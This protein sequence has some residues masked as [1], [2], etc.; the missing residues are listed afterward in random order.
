MAHSGKPLGLASGVRIAA[1]FRLLM[2]VR[3]LIAAVTVLLVPEER[4]LGSIFVVACIGALSA[5]ALFGWQEI[6]PRMLEYPVLLALDALIAYAVLEIGGVLGPFF[7]FTVVTSAV[8][9]LLFRWS[10]MMLICVLQ[11]LLYYAAATHGDG[12]TVGFQTALGM[13]LC[14]FIA[15]FVGTALRGLFD[16]AAE[17]DRARQRAEVTAAAA[18]ERARL[19]REMHDSLAKTL[20]GISMS[21][22]A[23]PIW[24]GKAPERAAEEAAKLASAA[25]IASREAR[26]LITEL[27]EDSV[28]QP[29]ANTVRQIAAAW[30][31]DIGVAAEV[32]AE[33][34]VDLPLRER[35]EV[36]AILK[37]ALENVKR[38]AEATAVRVELA[39][40]EGAIVMDVRDDGRGFAAPDGDMDGLARAGHY[41]VIG[42]RERAAHV[43]ASLDVESEP[44][45]GT[46]IRVTV[47]AR[48]RALE[49]A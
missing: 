46:S 39:V 47:P 26:E 25:E 13:P 35:H 27:R 22:A 11:V 28:Q 41:G 24:I 8:A 29:L 21:A 43:G 36:V 42:M 23:L 31:E 2:Q 49:V 32:S 7:F 17:A 12:W 5:L 3:V 45:R 48:Q 19:A 1:T 14:Y 10:G 40:R 20:R 4:R 16:E 30:S 6:V 37:E 18:E 9:G 38:H 33:P 34:G 44:G 15:G